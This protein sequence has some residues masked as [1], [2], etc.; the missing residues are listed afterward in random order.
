MSKTFY[1]ILLLLS[2][3]FAW[4]QLC[5]IGNPCAI[6]STI[7]FDDGNGNPASDGDLFADGE[8]HIIHG[9]GHGSNI[10]KPFFIVE[11]WDPNNGND[12]DYYTTLYGDL[13]TELTNNNYDVILLNYEF[14]GDYIQK[15]AF[16]LIALIEQINGMKVPNDEGVI[17]RNTVM[18][19]SMGGLVARY[20]LAYME[21]NGI[22]H[23][24]ENFVSHDSPQMGVSVPLSIQFLIN[25][26]ANAPLVWL[27]AAPTLYNFLSANPSA[28][29]ML[30]YYYE[31][32]RNGVPNPNALHTQF[33]DELHAL[34]P[35]Y[36]GFPVRTKNIG[37]S[38]GSRTNAIQTNN[39]AN[40]RLDPGDE[41]VYFRRADQLFE[42]PVCCRKFLFVCTK[43]CLEPVFGVIE[44][45]ALS[46]FV[47]GLEVDL[48]IL[49]DNANSEHDFTPG[50]DS[51]DHVAGSFEGILADLNDALD[52]NVD[53][54]NIADRFTFVPTTSA[55]HV[56]PDD[57]LANVG[58][59]I[60]NA[61]CETP[62]DA[63]YA[64][65]INREHYEL[66][67]DA[68]DFI[69]D[70]IGATD[71]PVSYAQGARVSIS[72]LT[73]DNTDRRFLTA[74]V[75]YTLPSSRGGAG[76]VI[77]NSGSELS[78]FAGS[79]IILQ[80]GFHARAGSEF[81]A[82]PGGD[83]ELHDISC[84]TPPTDGNTLA[85]ARVA[86]I[87][88]PEAPLDTADYAQYVIV[89]PNP[90]SGTF[91]IDIDYDLELVE[92]IDIVNDYQE[93]VYTNEN[94]QASNSITIS[95]PQFGY[96]YVIVVINGEVVTKRIIVR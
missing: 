80:D 70:E 95:S 66:R 52:G 72:S 2:S 83:W 23:E 21:A 5:P 30:V 46:G 16:L 58:S 63:V 13:I 44:A 4:A 18:G 74:A 82:R 77:L 25:D 45:R 69:L 14:A 31:D 81:F 92:R 84:Y 71:D 8:Y 56:G 91:S 68:R 40:G 60:R 47:D 6:R 1:L 33:F 96:H 86:P 19:Y 37:L 42:V 65:N 85:G 17:E 79:T 50:P 3:Q 73:L 51:Y 9:A 55:L 89:Y 41:L 28:K 76:E 61:D 59:N 75:S 32:S 94:P 57:P 39:D 12:F 49:G 64:E 67:P 22:E 27:V 54:L 93:V 20:A 24:T 29:Q 62:F 38:N 35:N 11:G 36:L 26:L 43:F 48:D 87:A 34:S 90:N 53:Q 10:V 15:N 88:A 7:S 78:V